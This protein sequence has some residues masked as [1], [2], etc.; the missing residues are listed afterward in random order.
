MNK[1]SLCFDFSYD[2]KIWYYGYLVSILIFIF[3]DKIGT[4]VLNNWEKFFL[5]IT[6]I[7]FGSV[8]G[9]ISH[10]L[11]KPKECISF[12]KNK[13]LKENLISKRDFDLLSYEASFV[14]IMVALFI[15]I[16]L[17]TS[18]HLYELIL[19]ASLIP[20][21]VAYHAKIITE[22]LKGVGFEEVTFIGKFFK[23]NLLL[24]FCFLFTL[25]PLKFVN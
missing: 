20:M 18:S 10:L 23:T 5:I 19:D 15:A 22:R 6:I 11:N 3:N 1:N 4:V 8:F 14:G 25:I 24:G 7:V 9:F 21:L 13:G 17:N 16:R 2:K 12:F